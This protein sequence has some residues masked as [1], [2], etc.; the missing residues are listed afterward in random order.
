MLR[1]KSTM[2]LTSFDIKEP[3]LNILPPGV[4][5]Y[6]VNGGGLTGNGCVGQEDSP[7]NL[8]C[9]TGRSH[10]NGSGNHQEAWTNRYSRK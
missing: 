3:G 1:S 6:I 4:E 2:K 7:G 9:G 10:T 8:D 5:R